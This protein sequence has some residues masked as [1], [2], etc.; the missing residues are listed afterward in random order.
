MLLHELESYVFV[1]SS[2]VTYAVD[3]EVNERFFL[4]ES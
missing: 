4:L 2:V 3:Q 1:S